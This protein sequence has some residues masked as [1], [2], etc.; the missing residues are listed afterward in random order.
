MCGNFVNSTCV[1]SQSDG[2]NVR[3][4]PN[5]RESGLVEEFPLSLFKGKRTDIN[6]GCPGGNARSCFTLSRLC[7]QV[8]KSVSDIKTE[9]TG[10]SSV[11][12][13]TPRQMAYQ[14]CL[15]LCIAVNLLIQRRQMVSRRQRETKGKEKKERNNV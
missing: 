14:T 8:S 15:Q 13:I 4:K 12:S 9:C 10:N 6:T 1:F 11:L 7:S 5:V 2:M 3:L